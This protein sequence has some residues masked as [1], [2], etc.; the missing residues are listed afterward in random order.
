M[1]DCNDPHTEDDGFRVV[2]W[3]EYVLHSSSI[4]RRV[5]LN[6]HS[7]SEIEIVNQYRDQSCGNGINIEKTPF[8][9]FVKAYTSSNPGVFWANALSQG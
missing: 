7:S 4:N 6:I 5:S 1:L 3:F 2:T 8:E 9:F